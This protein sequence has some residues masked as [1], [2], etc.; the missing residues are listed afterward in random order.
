MPPKNI[1][2]HQANSSA[3]ALLV[4]LLTV[5]CGPPPQGPT[6]SLPAYRAIWLQ[7]ADWTHADADSAA[8]RIRRFVT[9]ITPT[10]STTLLVQVDG[11]AKAADRKEFHIR[12]T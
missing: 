10:T 12:L 2:R 5:S 9:A 4:L 6:T 7:P 11:E 8:I 3:P 1:L